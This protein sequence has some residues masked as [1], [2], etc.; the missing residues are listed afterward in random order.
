MIR[1]N[2]LLD[3]VS[4]EI[5]NNRD[6][7]ELTNFIKRKYSKIS[8][9]GFKPSKVPDCIGKIDGEMMPLKLNCKNMRRLFAKQSVLSNIGLLNAKD[10]FKDISWNDKKKIPMNNSFDT[11]PLMNTQFPEKLQEKKIKKNIPQASLH[12]NF[13]SNFNSNDKSN[14]CRSNVASVDHLTQNPKSSFD[15]KE[16]IKTD[17]SEMME[18]NQLMN[19]KQR[20][21]SGKDLCSKQNIVFPSKLPM[22]YN[23]VSNRQLK[24]SQECEYELTPSN[25]HIKKSD[26]KDI[27][28]ISF[29]EYGSR[30]NIPKSAKIG[31]PLT[32]KY[33]TKEF[34][35]EDQNEMVSREHTSTNYKVENFNVTSSTCRM[36]ETKTNRFSS[37]QMKTEPV[38]LIEETDHNPYAKF[39]M[40]TTEQCA[41]SFDY[42]SLQI[43]NTSKILRH[44]ESKKMM[45][46]KEEIMILN[47]YANNDAEDFNFFISKNETKSWYINEQGEPVECIDIDFTD[48]KC[49]TMSKSPCYD[50]QVRTTG[51]KPL[52]YKTPKSATRIR[53]TTGKFDARKITKWR[54]KTELYSPKLYPGKFKISNQKSKDY[55]MES[56]P[57]VSQKFFD[58]I[59][60]TK[61]N[62][63]S[64]ERINS[65]S[66]YLTFV[67]SRQQYYKNVEKNNNSSVLMTNNYFRPVIFDNNNE[68][69]F[70]DTTMGLNQH[71]GL[72]KMKA[73]YYKD[74]SQYKKYLKLIEDKYGNKITSKTRNKTF[75]GQV[76][77]FLDT[78]DNLK[79]VESDVIFYLIDNS[80]RQSVCVNHVQSQ[81]KEIEA[82]FQEKFDKNLEITQII[83]EIEED[84]FVFENTMRNR[85]ENLSPKKNEKIIAGH[86][87]DF[88]NFIQTNVT[89]SLQ[90]ESFSENIWHSKAGKL[91]ND[92][93][94]TSG[95]L[96]QR[97]DDSTNCSKKLALNLSA[98]NN[99]DSS[100]SIAELPAPKKQTTNPIINIDEKLEEDSRYRKTTAREKL[101]ASMNNFLNEKPHEL[102]SQKK[103]IPKTHNFK[104]T[105]NDSG[106]RRYVGGTYLS[107]PNMDGNGGSKKNSSPKS[108]N[109]DTQT[110]Q[111]KTIASNPFQS[112][113]QKKMQSDKK[114]SEYKQENKTDS[115]EKLTP[116][117]CIKSY[118]IKP[119]NPSPEK[120]IKSYQIKPENHIPKFDS[121]KNLPT[122]FR[123]SENQSRQ[124]IK[125]DK[126]EF[127]TPLNEKKLNK[128]MDNSAPCNNFGSSESQLQ[129]NS[130]ILLDRIDSM[131]NFTESGIISKTMNEE[132]V[133][134][135]Q[136]QFEKSLNNNLTSSYKLLLESNRSFNKD[137]SSNMKTAVAPQYSLTMSSHLEDFNKFMTQMNS[138]LHPNSGNKNETSNKS[139]SDQFIT[140]RNY[141]ELN[142]SDQFT[143]N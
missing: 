119:E 129:L 32:H 34:I 22:V 128:Q 54:S 110:L 76:D 29:T 130:K 112:I 64:Q 41:P 85:L 132:K 4:R 127:Y 99:L 26:S 91:F 134:Q 79:K 113:N 116:E 142:I 82:E 49:I 102:Q 71:S 118:Q 30:M 19:D 6:I 105:F 124:K 13:M 20:L 137:S 39:F 40:Q 36:L 1:L 97:K 5:D 48:D 131:N 90:L 59:N 2:D 114:N 61:R 92:K 106:L 133:E 69:D 18:M 14:L 15:H 43:N 121:F 126:I 45:D 143:N 42:S 73:T 27:D 87:L 122:N 109:L 95:L 56:S 83:R 111:S 16:F 57:R 125:K 141:N 65:L 98:F 68:Y 123:D 72:D 115:N 86:K 55:D 31:A 135:Y 100:K 103:M 12:F 88:N 10:F 52:R 139:E 51:K 9:E 46:T 8:L 78:I 21:S 63:Y 62:T 107:L 53:R 60:L 25:N 104:F 58:L 89:D 67:E 70:E 50:K 44:N 37:Q 117:K 35:I 7:D 93:N 24:R 3:Y 17:I 136:N 94:K 81:V 28:L 140:A 38:P 120:C 75:S 108:F 66:E 11:L 80:D 74:Q 33:E 101:E 47:D 23:S 77:M 84:S 138:K 96:D